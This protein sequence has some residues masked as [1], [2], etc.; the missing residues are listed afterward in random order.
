MAR[1][2]KRIGSGRKE[3]SINVPKLTAYFTQEEVRQFVEDLKERAKK[4]DRIAVFVGEHLFGKPAQQVGFDEQT[5]QLI[6]D[7]AFAS[8]STSNRS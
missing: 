7:N 6:F 3:G 4:S 1:G 8:V 2:G 5:I